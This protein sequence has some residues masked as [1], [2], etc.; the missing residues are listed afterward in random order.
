M[1]GSDEVDGNRED[2]AHTGRERQKGKWT[3][4]AF[5]SYGKDG[6]GW[7]MVEKEIAGRGYLPEV[8]GYKVENKKA[9]GRRPVQM[10][11]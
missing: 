7:M 11:R 5:Q 9:G 1:V 10:E 6:Q 8:V 3:D 4:R 2:N